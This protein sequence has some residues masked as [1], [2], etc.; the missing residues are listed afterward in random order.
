M[1]ITVTNVNAGTS[2]REVGKA[3]SKGVDMV[4]GVIVRELDSFKSKDELEEYGLKFGIDLDKKFKL[5]NMY[6]TLMEQ[7]DKLR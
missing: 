7:V 2:K 3:I 1:G 4:N 5:E 6:K